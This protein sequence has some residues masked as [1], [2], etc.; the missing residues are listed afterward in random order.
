[1]A[2]SFPVVLAD[3]YPE[4]FCIEYINEYPFV[5]DAMVSESNAGVIGDGRIEAAFALVPNEK[6]T[7]LSR[8]DLP[9]LEPYDEKGYVIFDDPSEY[10][11]IPQ[12]SDVIRAV[13][14]SG[15]TT[16]TDTENGF[17]FAVNVDSEKNSLLVQCAAHSVVPGVLSVNGYSIDTDE[18]LLPDGTRYLV[19]SFVL[20]NGP[21][22]TDT[23]VSENVVY[24]FDG[25]T[26]DILTAT[27]EII[28]SPGSSLLDALFY[29]EWGSLKISSLEWLD[30][31]TESISG[32]F[33]PTTLPLLEGMIEQFAPVKLEATVDAG[34]SVYGIY[35]WSFLGSNVPGIDA[36]AIR[37]DI[38]NIFNYIRPILSVNNV[39]FDVY[40]YLLTNGRTDLISV[41]GTLQTG[42]SIKVPVVF[43][44]SAPRNIFV[45]GNYLR[46]LDGNEDGT[47]AVSSYV[48][49]LE[50]SEPVTDEFFYYDHGSFHVSYLEG[51]NN[52]TENISGN[53]SAAI[54]PLLENMT[55]QL[56]PVKFE[57]TVDTG[58]SVYGIYEWS[59]MGIDIPNINADAI[60]EDIN[61]I[62]NYVRPVISVDGIAFDVYDYLSTNGKMDLLNVSGSLQAGISINVPVVLFD[63]APRNVSIEGGYLYI[64]DGSQNGNIAVGSYIGIL[65]AP[66]PALDTFFY[67]DYGSFHALFLEDLE[68][69]T[70]SISGGFSPTTLP[71]LEG[72]IEQ[73]APVKLEATVDTGSSV[74]GVYEWSFLGS[75]VPGIDANAIR[76]D[77]NNI[78]N[79]VRPVIFVGGI[80]FDVYDYLVTNGK[81]NLLNISGSF[82]AG[83]S[84]KMPVVLL[85]KIPRNI[86]VE[87]DYLYISDGS[88][89]GILTVSF[90]I[91][92]LET[93]ASEPILDAQFYHNYGSFNVSPLEDL[94][95]QTTIIS[96][97]FFSE[98]QPLLDNMT[99][100]FAPVKLE[101]T[102]DAGSSV[103]G[104]YEWSFLGS[105]VPG[106]DVNLIREDI[107]NIFNYI[108]PVLSVNGVAFDVYDYLLTN[109]KTNLL[110]VSGSS[111][112][113]F[114]IKVPAVLSDKAPRGV[115][116]E[117]G[118]LRI[119]DGNK[120]GIL[121]VGSYIGILEAPEP[122][123][124]TFFY[125]DYG[126][127]HALFLEDL[128][129]QTKSISG[130]FSV[131]TPPLLD[132]ITM[133]IA[134]VVF[135][136][137][138][139]AGSSAYGIY[140]WRFVGSD[141][142]GINAD[143]VRE[144]INNIFNYVRPVLSVGDVVFD[145]YDYLI[146][147]E[148]I[149]L[150]SISGSFQTGFSIKVPVVL[151]DKAPRSVSIKENYICISDGN[152][153]GALAVSSYIGILKIPAPEPT[154]DMLFYHDYG[155]FK[156]MSLEELDNQTKSISG[157][158]S[159]TELPLFGEIIDQLTPVKL[160]ATV[161]TGS[162][163]YGVYEW[164][165]LGSNVPG[166]DANAIREDI[167]NIFNYVRPIF[168]V[169]GVVFDVYDYLAVNGRTDL[170]NISGSL[171]VGFSIK[172][173]VILIDK[174]P[175]SI[176]VEENYL[177]I[178]DGN[179]N[180]IVVIG[181]YVGI[182][183]SFDEVVESPLLS[184]QNI[185]LEKADFQFQLPEANAVFELSET[186]TWPGKEGVLAAAPIDSFVGTYDGVGKYAPLKVTISVSTAVL[187]SLSQNGYNAMLAA[188]QQDPT[189]FFD[190][191][192]VYKKIGN[193]VYDLVAMGGKEAFVIFG[194][195]TTKINISF[196][197]ALID[198]LGLVFFDKTKSA[199]I[200]YDG[201]GDGKLVD[202]LFIGAIALEEPKEKP[203]Q[204]VVSSPSIS[205]RLVDIDTSSLGL[206]EAEADFEYLGLTDWPGK[207]GVLKAIS[208][209]SFEGEYDGLGKY[210]PLKMEVSVTSYDLGVLS[211]D[212]QSKVISKWAEDRS[213]FL[214]Y[215]HVY[216]QIGDTVYDL[217]MVGGKEAFTISGDPTT[218]VTI[219]FPAIL[220]DDMGNPY[221]D[222]AI[223]FVI[224]DGE[225]DGK[226]VDPLFVGT[227]EQVPIE[228]TEGTE[229][230]EEEETKHILPDNPAG[231]STG[232]DDLG[233]WIKIFSLF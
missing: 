10:L 62:F 187:S 166:I 60:R 84:I 25:L 211:K 219:S 121:V 99:I 233:K 145:V 209:G 118:Y 33:S 171:Q 37:E 81:A 29:H 34:S 28:G 31:Q 174:A 156:V 196:N 110:S 76:E 135:E 48:G 24:V 45:E 15:E 102:V 41:S 131:T 39:T 55:A 179:E 95:D 213:A 51:L 160:E 150:F 212:R 114:S 103:Y 101:A 69:Q 197:M 141:I 163:V 53:F 82:Q 161:D 57:A 155:S 125:H 77:I 71:L 66:E 159:S 169:N 229:E 195:P 205:L 225:K 133:Q 142:S 109:G 227:P 115:S 59:F 94:E 146:T 139:D 199:F 202:P 191:F 122:A 192:H 157:E 42:V 123:L 168:S 214:D 23:F 91:G 88:E 5:Y 58:S 100:Q 200:I 140:E 98:T 112:A 52:Q 177:R 176:S 107:N 198:D 30:N 38:N 35:E 183:R 90:Y 167:N 158:F 14:S 164:S 32:G 215:F 19:A 175:R 4:T 223:G 11:S 208:V 232:H 210:V 230:D 54:L 9:I 231:S 74:Y 61:N 132:N 64:S 6:A 137:T 148:K 8:N 18:I 203:A 224:Y 151:S 172:I 12:V 40:D 79:Y 97:E 17:S 119:S 80:A 220:I 78:F 111:Q 216:K 193:F 104:I 194:D 185:R 22:V 134:P 222:E 126:S 173:P 149:N 206:E 50:I 7:G 181:S 184:T 73:L 162:S 116:V 127:F 21:F 170:L 36:N 56:A 63:K 129:D 154:L 165:F 221:Y 138:I 89:D 124:D 113:G 67:H 1:M 27:V 201:I 47:L 96:G 144:N 128:E 152:K 106:I 188:W 85:D 75:N 178:S 130:G 143:F 147:N 186:A 228:E 136:A 120:D 226:L 68:N 92:I 117:E 87:E 2:L 70:E 43:S 49:V 182:V 189:T 46:I 72:M 190:Y 83:F 105:D 218:K 20:V 204:P 65:E 217:V 13:I 3:G 93:P 153:D 86:S 26:D 207:E 44:D 180:G 108:R 16:F